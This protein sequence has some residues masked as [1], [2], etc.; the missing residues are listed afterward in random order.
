MPRVSPGQ[1]NFLGGE[2]SPLAQGRIDSDRY[3]TGMATC[4]NWIPTLQG[5]IT[6]RTGTEYVMESGNRVQTDTVKLIPF[7]FSGTQ[8]Y[9]IELNSNGS[10]RFYKNRSLILNTATLTITNL[11]FA[12]SAGTT[13]VTVTSPAHGLGTDALVYLQNIVGTTELNN[14]Q[15]KIGNVTANTFVLYD[16]DNLF[17]ATGYGAYVSGGTI[18]TPYTVAHQYIQP[19]DVAGVKF[20]QSDDTIFLVHSK[21]P[22]VAYGRF[23]DNDW[24]PAWINVTSIDGPYLSINRTST[25][26]TP[27]ATTGTGITLTAS[28][29]LFDASFVNR[30]LRILIGTVWGFVTITSVTDA[31]HAV[32]NVHDGLG[33]TTATQNWRL[34]LW[35]YP[36]SGLSYNGGFPTCVCFHQDRLCF[37][38]AGDAPQRVDMSSTGGYGN[39]TAF[40]PD[41]DHAGAIT[42]STACSFNLNSNDINFI[43]WLVSSDQG[44]LAGSLNAEWVLTPSQAGGAITP[45]NINATQQTKYG[46]ESIQPVQAGKAALFVQRHGRKLRELLYYYLMNGYTAMDLTVLSEHITAPSITQL[47][48]QKELQPIVWALRSD[49]ALLGMT[50]QREMQDLNAGWH[51]HLIGGSID[52]YGTPAQVQSIA[53]IPSEDGTYDELWLAVVRYV[54]GLKRTQIEV[55]TKTLEVSDE[56]KDA[57]YVDSGLTYD[58]PVSITAVAQN[59]YQFTSVAHGLTTGDQIRVYDFIEAPSLNNQVYSVTKVDNDH[60]TLNGLNGTSLFSGTASLGVYRKLITTV[61]G[62]FHLEGQTVSILSDGAPQNTQVVTK[63]KITLVQPAA[64]VTIGLGYNSDIKLLRTEAGAA[65]GVALGKTRRIHR[66]GMLLYRT[67]G[68][69]FG[70][71]FDSLSPVE[72]RKISDL[73]GVAT[74]LYSGII[75][76]EIEAE[77]DFENQLCIRVSDPVPATIVAVMPQLETQDRG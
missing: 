14:R 52:A 45:T 43:S 29:A 69:R 22:P 58:N 31:T 23:A 21:Y 36:T 9:M 64:V 62:L 75:S 55:L 18:A 12:V 72:F 26:I 65:D 19:G 10:M 33:G 49:G 56:Q 61:G 48:Y 41:N 77:Y 34:G 60:F 50:Y 15:F 53:V 42:D 70:M 46:S 5:G 8:V 6:R 35:A 7:E 39:L 76:E 13:Y 59:P 37:A 25:T 51:R 57:F 68:I 38:G 27:S 4:L 44:L 71:D 17:D 54:N 32:A 11:S 20:T 73:Y 30:C 74:P 47:A 2:F 28:A 1:T 24:R 63:G 66:V 3:K 16:L 40:S 67:L